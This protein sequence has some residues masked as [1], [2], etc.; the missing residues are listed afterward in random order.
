M[1]SF[2]ASI[3][4]RSRF[5]APKQKEF[6]N[7]VSKT[8]RR[9][10]FQ[11][12]RRS[13]IA[14][15]A[16]S[17]CERAI[18][19]DL[20]L[21]LAGNRRE[22]ENLLEKYQDLFF[23][24]DRWPSP[25]RV[26]QL[27]FSLKMT[28]AK[29]RK[30]VL[31][32]RETPDT[33]EEEAKEAQVVTG[34]DRK[35]DASLPQ[36]WQL[37]SQHFHA[38]EKNLQSLQKTMDKHGFRYK[39]MQLRKLY[40]LVSFTGKMHYNVLHELFGFPA[41]STVRDYRKQL[42]NEVGVS[43]NLLDGK[44][45]HIKDVIARFPISSTDRRCV[46]SIDATYVKCNFGVKVDGTVIGSVVP[47]SI[48]KQRAA[49]MSQD[50]HEFQRFRQEN[51][52]KIAKA[53]FVILLNPLSV[54]E[55][56]FPVAV[57]PHS[58]GQM[59]DVIL[60]KLL[61]V[62]NTIRKAGFDLVGN[63]F[64][65]DGKFTQY[66]SLLCDEMLKQA[67][68]DLTATVESVFSDIIK[69]SE[70]VPM[71]DPNHQV[72]CDRYRRTLPNDVCVY[73]NMEPTIH[74]SDFVE[75]IGVSESVMS[76]SEVYKM[77]DVIPR[78]LFNIKNLLRSV[79]VCRIDLFIAL[80]PSTA[81]LTAIMEEELSRRER[82]D[83]L[84]YAW[85]F[86]F[87]YYTSLLRYKSHKKRDSQTTRRSKDKPISLWH[88]DHVKRYLSS[89]CSIVCALLDPRPINIGALGSHHNENFFGQIKKMSNYD[90]SIERFIKATEHTL[91]MR[92]L[93]RDFEISASPSGRKSMAG[94]K[95]AG[96]KAIELPSLGYYFYYA[97]SLLE[98]VHPYDNEE[99]SCAINAFGEANQLEIWDTFEN[100]LTLL[101]SSL[102]A[103]DNGK[104]SRGVSLRSIRAVNT[105]GVRCRERFISSSQ[106]FS[107]PSEGKQ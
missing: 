98:L 103:K 8:A 20:F 58:K 46:L 19:R 38:S 72:K 54:G 61:M 96:E 53:V 23:E 86:M 87:L 100:V 44:P 16:I 66:A 99:L 39:D 6:V 55:H 78:L 91:L 107:S 30:A 18:T 75:L 7:E 105:C 41:W 92:K 83:L 62:N 88:A 25:R 47:M 27:E 29:L 24:P 59:D 5:L 101:P 69:K 85:C 35:D 14:F 50:L 48:D 65:G 80:F 63:G 32:Q 77:D 81:L 2:D 28:R 74:R 9:L 40:T 102:L 22:F 73:F 11:Q 93:L 26:Q 71:F 12:L 70:I 37:V 21:G 36:W 104:C 45:K 52:D 15:N 13:Q 67:V 82:I 56:E 60:A 57:L 31:A 17:L 90:E 3:A 84:L 89:V 76:G 106:T 1:D 97:K 10:G 4:V 68:K 34:E 49:S 95:I 64:D 51:L 79:E 33:E 42:Q 43:F 94:A